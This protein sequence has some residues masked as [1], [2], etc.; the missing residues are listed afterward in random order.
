MTNWFRNLQDKD[1]FPGENT[2]N[3]QVD[4]MDVYEQGWH[5]YM[6]GGMITDNPYDI[7]PRA[8]KE[9]IRGFN[10]AQTKK[11]EELGGSNEQLV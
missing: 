1:A 4:L 2:H 10:D 6:D 3:T 9:W 7:D 8:N 11:T 5:S